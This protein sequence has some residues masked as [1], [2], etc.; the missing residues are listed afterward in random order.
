MDQIIELWVRTH[1]KVLHFSTYFFTKKEGVER[2]LG[3]IFEETLYFQ[4]SALQEGLCIESKP[5][6]L[7][8]ALNIGRSSV[9]GLLI[10]NIITDFSKRHRSS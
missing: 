8:G 1:Y 6:I 2:D 9:P 10:F 3:F 5:Y 4:L 7:P